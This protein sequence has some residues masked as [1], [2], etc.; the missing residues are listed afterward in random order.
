M[1]DTTTAQDGAPEQA[2]ARTDVWQSPDYTV[3]ETALEVTGYLL[4]DR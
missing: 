3:V 4:A 2:A 1:Q